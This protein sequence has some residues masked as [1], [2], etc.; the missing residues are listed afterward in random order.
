MGDYTWR[1]GKGVIT[2]RPSFELI[3]GRRKEGRK[4]M[5][6]GGNGVGLF[7][8]LFKSMGK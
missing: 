5:K 8:E 1:K 2:I 7:L 4:E 3:Y 6:G